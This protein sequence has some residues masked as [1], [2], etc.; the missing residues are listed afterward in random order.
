M[1]KFLLF[2][3]LLGFVFSAMA[4]STK[5]NEVKAPQGHVV[6]VVTNVVTPMNQPSGLPI[7]QVNAEGM[8]VTIVA[9]GTAGNAY[10]LLAGG[11]TALWA[12]NDLNTVVMTHRAASPGT[13]YLRVDKSTDNGSTWTSDIG[14]VYDP[15]VTGYS[16]ARYP[17]GVLYNPTGNTNPDNAVLIYNAPILDGTNGG[18]WGGYGYGTHVLDSS[19]APTQN[20]VTTDAASGYFLAV[21]DGMTINGNEVFITDAAL[22]GGT[23]DSYTDTVI[24][25]KYT[26]GT[27]NALS[28]D[29]IFIPFE[30]TDGS[31][32][33]DGEKAWLTESKIAFAPD[34]QTGFISMLTHHDTMLVKDEGYYPV[35]LKT[36]DGG[37]TW[38]APIEV[39][40]QNMGDLISM[41]FFSDQELTDYFAPDAPPARSEL[42]FRCAFDHDLV[43]D[44]NGN[45]HFCAS[46][47]V[48]DLVGSFSVLSPANG[49]IM[50]I[51]D[52]YSTD[53]GVTWDAKLLSRVNVFRGDF[54]GISEDNRAQAGVT[55]DGTKVFFSWLDTDTLIFGSANG[56]FN[57]DIHVIGFDPVSGN[58]TSPMNVTQGTIGDGAAMM[59]TMSHYVFGSATTGTYE[60]P[61]V[62][63]DFDP[64]N[65]VSPTTYYYIS[66]VI[67]TDADFVSTND[68][69][70]SNIA[71]S[72][73][74][75]NPFS[76]T[77]NIDVTLDNSANVSI[78]VFN[79]MGQQVYAQDYGKLPAGQN[80][81]TINGSDLNTGMYFF[82]VT[83]GNSQVTKKMT[84]K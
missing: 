65:P 32:M 50:G 35:F 46:V 60:V 28:L 37:A 66:D 6:D 18:S 15:T 75:P 39:P 22:N 41:D 10:G 24:V 34:G 63:Q 48:G 61:L 25:T 12:D 54:G 23:F 53:G 57:P 38:S 72:Q 36:T 1:K 74:Y 3:F 56:N 27:G 79:M 81:I 80:Q 29:T 69:E 70:K 59:G 5:T 64:T 4:Q 52:I 33:S 71:V 40:L 31:K 73:N 42:W 68:I 83:A 43:V 11:K 7:T 20:Y 51:F 78:N 62:Y 17:Q 21:C 76:T 9:C 67:F 84:I 8:A 19:V 58:L 55:M 47:C 2:T 77:T 13:G 30:T 26:V 44:A 16:N 45:P 14:P 82:T 49:G